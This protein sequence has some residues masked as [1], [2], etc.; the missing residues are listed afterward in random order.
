MSDGNNVLIDTAAKGVA[1]A[2]SVADG[3]P[4]LSVR[5]AKSKVFATKVF[6]VSEILRPVATLRSHKKNSFMAAAPAPSLTPLT[7]IGIP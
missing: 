3:V 5:P 6:T 7:R 1:A 4:V 2:A